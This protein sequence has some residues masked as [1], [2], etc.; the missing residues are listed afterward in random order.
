MLFITD[1]ITITQNTIAAVITSTGSISLSHYSLVD[2]IS[3]HV[4]IIRQP[5]ITKPS[6]TCIFYPHLSVETI[7]I[8]PATT[9]TTSTRMNTDA[10]LL[11]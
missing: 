7:M 6:I 9:I 4:A 8:I 3:I 5:N 2:L 11:S 1:E 10:Y